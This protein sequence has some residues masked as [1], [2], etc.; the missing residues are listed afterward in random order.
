M[1]P[2]SSGEHQRVEAVE[3]GAQRADGL[4]Q[5]IAEHVDGLGGVGIVLPPVQQG[6]Q[7]GADA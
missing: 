3:C 7:I 5:L 2:D 1:L 4:A 6:L